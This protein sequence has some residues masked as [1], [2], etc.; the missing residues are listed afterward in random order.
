M[1]PF[2]GHQWKLGLGLLAPF[3]L[4]ELYLQTL[5]PRNWSLWSPRLAQKPWGCQQT[6][7]SS[8]QFLWE[9]FTT[10]EDSP[11]P[12]NLL[13]VWRAGVVQ[14]TLTWRREQLDKSRR[15]SRPI[16]FN[17]LQPF[18]WAG[19]KKVPI[20]ATC[21]NGHDDGESCQLGSGLTQPVHFT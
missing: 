18:S 2:H 7:V 1:M 20:T 3:L 17:I 16:L 12:L 10:S 8:S 21:S 5:S 11:L 15:W 4:V 13:L 6:A 19:L 9:V 14:A